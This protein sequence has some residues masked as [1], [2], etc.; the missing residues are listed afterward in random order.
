MTKL[1]RSVG[2]ETDAA[3]EVIAKLL[4][5]TDEKVRMAA[6]TKLLDLRKEIAVIINTDEI[7]RLMLESKNPE[8]GKQL[9]VDE[10]EDDPAYGF[11]VIEP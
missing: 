7:Q 4:E 3:V 8:R 10:D 5:S 2:K 1:L 9:S 6:A 11:D